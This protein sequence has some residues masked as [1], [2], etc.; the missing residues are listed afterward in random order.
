[1][2]GGQ[3]GKRGGGAVK[4][5]IQRGRFNKRTSPKRSLIDLLVGGALAD[6]GGENDNIKKNAQVRCKKKNWGN[7]Q[8]AQKKK[9]PQKWKKSGRDGDSSNGQPL[10]GERNLIKGEWVISTKKQQGRGTVWSTQ[11]GCSI[12]KA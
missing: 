11:G 2:S 4:K 10:P 1:M 3:P 5:G 6:K 7:C 8:G 12:L 9:N